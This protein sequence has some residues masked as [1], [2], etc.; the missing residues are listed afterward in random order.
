MNNEDYEKEKEKMRREILEELEKDQMRKEILDELNTK[1]RENPNSGSETIQAFG[2]TKKKSTVSF[3]KKEEEPSLEAIDDDAIPALEAVDVAPKQ[4]VSKKSKILFGVCLVIVI[5]AIACFPFIYDKANDIIAKIGNTDYIPVPKEPEKQYE[6]IT[7]DSE[8]FKNLKYPTMH[9]DPTTEDTYYS[10]DKITTNDFTNNDLLYRALLDVLEGNMA[11]YSG[12][13][14][15]K[16]CGTGATKVSLDADYLELRLQG[17]FTRNIN[18]TLTDFT[19]PINRAD[20]KYVGTWKYDAKNQRFIYYGCGTKAK[21]NLVY[22]DISVPY[23]VS[24]SDK[25]VNLYVDSYVAFAVVNATNRDYILYKD[26]AYTEELA[27]GTLKTNDFEEELKA[28]VNDMEKKDI[29]KYKYT[30]T[31]DGC[32]YLDYCFAS[33]EWVK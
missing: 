13:Y 32:P 6:K 22:Y 20:T 29:N 14:S 21:A 18:Y 11:P 31:I 12:K 3:N 23:E 17:L 5:V 2:Q 28:V 16:Y 10:R 26:A 30:Y 1:G 24:T 8:I 19:V 7:M 9:N 15:G 25:N 33:G 27:K 4:P